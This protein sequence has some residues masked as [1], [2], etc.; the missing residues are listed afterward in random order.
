MLSDRQAKHR[1]DI[2]ERV[3]IESKLT[4]AQRA[5][6]LESGGLRYANRMG[7]QRRTHL[8]QIQSHCFPEV[9]I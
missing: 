7:W 3:A 1:K 4:D 9:L 6:V 8:E 5:E 2:F